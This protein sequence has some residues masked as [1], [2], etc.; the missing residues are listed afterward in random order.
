MSYRLE[1]RPGGCDV[2][3]GAISACADRRKGVATGRCIASYRV[4][5]EIVYQNS[6]ANARGGV[7]YPALDVWDGVGAVSLE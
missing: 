2:C 4:V 1:W 5:A 3:V 7:T 6:S